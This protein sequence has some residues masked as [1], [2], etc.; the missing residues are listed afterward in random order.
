MKSESAYGPPARSEV[1]V[2]DVRALDGASRN[3]E[4]PRS[5]IYLHPGQIFASSEPTV[6]TTIVGS[7]VAICLWDSVH[8]QAGMNHY[9]LPYGAGEGPSGARFGNVAIERLI[10]RLL[11]LGSRKKDLQAKLFGGACVIEAF[12][13]R[14]NHLGRK[15]V[16]LARRLLKREEISVVS[17]DVGGTNGRKLILHSDNGT[18]WV[19]SL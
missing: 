19:R 7:C 5:S 12:K 13:N 10:G 9:L 1:V 3:G 14:Q 17:E 18:V 4:L 11:E 2:E 15:N 6:V 16:E 8:R